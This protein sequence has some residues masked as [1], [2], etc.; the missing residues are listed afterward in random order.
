[1]QVYASSKDRYKIEYKRVRPEMRHKQTR[2]HL[3]TK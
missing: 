2:A 1:M 3:T